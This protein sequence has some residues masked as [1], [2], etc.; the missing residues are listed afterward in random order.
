M[1]MTKIRAFVLLTI[2]LLV[3]IKPAVACV[4]PGATMTPVER[5]CCHHMAEQCGSSMMPASHSCCKAQGPTNTVLPQ[6]Q[7]AGPVRPLTIAVIPPI[8]SLG[9]LPAATVHS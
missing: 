7:A 3:G 9:A 1:R 8:T 2:G 6:A 5:E 4:L